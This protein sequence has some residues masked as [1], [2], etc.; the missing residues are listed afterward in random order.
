VVQ[1][2][3]M[4]TKIIVFYYVFRT[5]GVFAM[6]AAGREDAAREG[7]APLLFVNT[8]FPSIVFVLVINGFL[9]AY[10]FTSGRGLRGKGG[11][12]NEGSSKMPF[13]FEGSRAPSGINTMW[14]K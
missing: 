12:A 6:R 2:E 5:V 11:E 10:S 3:D 14:K 7:V 13:R 9:D 1:N 4:G 8:F